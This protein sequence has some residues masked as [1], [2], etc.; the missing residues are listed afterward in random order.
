MKQMSVQDKDVS[1]LLFMYRNV[2]RSRLKYCWR[3]FG[4]NILKSSHRKVRM[5][6]IIENLE[7]IQ[8]IGSQNMVPKPASSVSFQNCLLMNLPVMQETQE[9]RVLPLGGEDPLKEE[10]AT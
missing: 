5:L 7:A 4:G 3:K 2:K 1:I 6:D 9:T 10:M 8:F